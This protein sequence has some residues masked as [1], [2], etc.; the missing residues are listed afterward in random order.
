MAQFGNY[1]NNG[2]TAVATIEDIGRHRKGEK[3]K[4]WI[5]L[6]VDDDHLVD[7]SLLARMPWI[8]GGYS[9]MGQLLRGHDC[10]ETFIS[11]PFS[12]GNHMMP[13]H[14]QYL[15]DQIEQIAPMHRLL[16]TFGFELAR[17]SNPLS[18]A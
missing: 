3:L 9:L 5:Y 13:E 2:H 18:V 7:G 11:I 17:V 16:S 14:Q 10:V 15:L 6:F 8:H 1:T 4:G 12:V